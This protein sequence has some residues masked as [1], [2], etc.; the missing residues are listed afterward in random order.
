[1]RR[2]L[3]V[4]ALCILPLSPARSAT[5]Y[6]DAKNGNDSNSGTSPSSAWKSLKKLNTYQFQP[7]DSILLKRGETFREQLN[8]PS[9]GAEGRPIVLDVYGTGEL[10]VISGA[11]PVPSDSWNASPTINIWQANVA[12]EPNVVIFDGAKGN[13]QTAL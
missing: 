10:P 8:F 3:I 7:G 6:V 5:Y 11:D 12:T 2:H 9:S 4:F 13:K 1:M